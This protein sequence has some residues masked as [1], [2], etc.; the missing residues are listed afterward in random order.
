MKASTASIVIGLALIC[1]AANSQSSSANPYGLTESEWRNLGGPEFRA[2]LGVA[3]R[4][5]E[6]ETAADRGEI[7]AM[8]IAAG[9]LSS[10]T[11][12]PPDFAKAYRYARKA[13][14]LGSPRAMV[15]LGYLLQQGLGVAQDNEQA[16]AW[17]L[18][19]AEL[20]QFQGM[21]NAASMLESGSGVPKDDAKALAWYR[22]AAQNNDPL[23]QFYLA[24]ALSN[25]LGGS[26]DYVGAFN[27]M[28]LAAEG[29]H[30]EAM[31]W[32]ATWLTYPERSG[33][34]VDDTEATRWFRL[35]V[36]AGFADAKYWYARRLLYGAGVNADPEQA[37]A[38]L[39]E[40]SANGDL[41]AQY[42]MGELLV[43]GE[44]GV[45][46]NRGEAQRIFSS[47]ANNPKA[48]KHMVGQA[49]FNQ[50]VIAELDRNYEAARSFYAR[51][52][53][54]GYV[55]NQNA[56]VNVEKRIAMSAA[57][58]QS[59][60]AASTMAPG[61]FSPLFWGPVPIADVQ[62][63][64]LSTD[65]LRSD[66][67]LVKGR[68]YTMPAGHG[69]KAWG[70]PLGSSPTRLQVLAS[71]NRFHSCIERP[72]TPN[73]VLGMELSAVSGVTYEEWSYG[74][75][76]AIYIQ[77]YI[78][79]GFFRGPS[80]YWLAYFFVDERL[81]AVRAEMPIYAPATEGMG[82][83]ILCSPEIDAPA[84][85]LARV[86]KS[87]AGWKVYRAVSLSQTPLDGQRLGHWYTLSRPDAVMHIYTAGWPN[88]TIEGTSSVAK[89]GRGWSNYLV[90]TPEMNAALRLDGSRL[91]FLRIGRN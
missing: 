35:A 81:V 4:R 31:Y 11:W 64:V 10:D 80:D 61:A 16:F 74:N 71:A 21:L 88:K 63:L 7:F 22:R 72:V 68:N 43:K 38:L 65:Q 29:G 59:D 13:A 77:C 17:A 60:T 91:P 90:A 2:R 12:G 19:A 54:A 47:L 1:T 62:K 53:A 87:E 56:L 66:L 32:Y 3:D 52:K 36:Q 89:C 39:R 82:D 30:A 78:G 8:T 49:L 9:A 18:K 24:R 86:Q 25:G 37:I 6:I 20:G 14:E 23:A 46:A 75:R 58:Q 55:D 67:A 48:P 28:K 51:A 45:P 69:Y 15:T 5:A 40:S 27:A 85:V 84:Q 83:R 57:V 42:F 76:K 50:G 41:N 44:N 26:Q 33:K 79:N 73:N 70:L 34:P